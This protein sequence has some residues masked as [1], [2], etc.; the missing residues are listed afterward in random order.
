[1]KLEVFLNGI[2]YVTLTYVNIE[3]VHSTY[4]LSRDIVIPNEVLL[5]RDTNC[6]IHNQDIDNFYKSIMSVLKQATIEC[7]PNSSN[8]NKKFVPIPG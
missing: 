7:I 1:M 6:S 8:N 2:K 4:T 5:C 3:V